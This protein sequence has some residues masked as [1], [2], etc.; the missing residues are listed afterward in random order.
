M[1]PNERAAAKDI[2]Y[3]KLGGR[4]HDDASSQSSQFFSKTGNNRR[5]IGGH[6][7]LLN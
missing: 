4:V 7:I 3:K 5:A 2:P 6:I 1:N